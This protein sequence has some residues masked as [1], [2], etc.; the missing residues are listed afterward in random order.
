MVRPLKKS[1]ASSADSRAQAA[2]LSTRPTG[3]AIAAN[4]AEFVIATK[5]TR[6]ASAK[7]AVTHLGNN[8]KNMVQSVEASLKRLKTDRIDL[9]FVQMDDFEGQNE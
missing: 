3:E 2:I 7:P 1:G 6:G 4:R 5:Y 8:R 9:Y